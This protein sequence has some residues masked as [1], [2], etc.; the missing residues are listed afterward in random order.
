MLVVNSATGRSKLEMNARLSLRSQLVGQFHRPHG[1]LGHVAAWILSIRPSNRRRN[2]WTVDLLDLQPA[3]R[4]LEIGYGAGLA[5]EAASGM[6]TTGRVV[7][8]DHS[9]QMYRTARRRNAAAVRAGRVELHCAAFAE[10]PKFEQP[11]DKVYTVNVLPFGKEPERLIGEM[12]RLLRPGGL[13]ATTFQPRNPG[14]TDEDA[15]RNG[16][17][18]AELFRRLGFSDVRVEVLSL[19]PVCAV[20]VLGR[21]PIGSD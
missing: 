3:D 1:L 6:A 14:A 2:R 21:T 9:E 4:V 16:E 7:G 18:R 15:R 10:L 17:A 11:F 19:E 5:I 20:C 8:V 12:V 13:L